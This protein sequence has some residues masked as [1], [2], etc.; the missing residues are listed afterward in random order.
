[1]TLRRVVHQFSQSVTVPCHGE[2][3]NTPEAQMTL[4]NAHHHGAGLDGV[5]KNFV[6]CSNRRQCAGRRYPKVV[7][8]L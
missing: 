3:L 7:H 5:S 4:G 6:A 8:G 1:M 2:I